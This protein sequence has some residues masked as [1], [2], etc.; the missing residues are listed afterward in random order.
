MTACVH[1]QLRWTREPLQRRA[2]F[3]E[4]FAGVAGSGW[5]SSRLV[6]D[7]CSRQR[8]TPRLERRTPSTSATATSTETWSTSTR[9]TCLPST[10]S[11]A[12]SRASPSALAACQCGDPGGPARRSQAVVTAAR[13][14][15]PRRA[16]ASPGP[17]EESR[18][19]LGGGERRPRRSGACRGPRPWP[20]TPRTPCAPARPCP[21]A[22]CPPPGERRGLRTSAASSSTSSCACCRS[23]SPR[24]S[25]SRT[26]PA[27]RAAVT[28]R[29]PRCRA[30]PVPHF[31]PYISPASP[32]GGR[33][34]AAH[35]ARVRVGGL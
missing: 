19:H 27:S 6:G 9:A 33:P 26:C 13:A 11:L 28:R 24:C 20:S 1:P 31:L 18:C 32:V 16:Q 15:D 29:A 10:C 34:D 7:A 14:R 17:G 30:C 5:G 21:R 35:A 12:A 22:P 25:S 4:L 2:D 8:S 3:V 23:A